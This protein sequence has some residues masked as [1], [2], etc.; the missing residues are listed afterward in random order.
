MLDYAAN[1]ATE[2]KGAVLREWHAERC[3][4]AGIDAEEDLAAIE[5]SL[6][7][8]EAFWARVGENLLLAVEVRQFIAGGDQILQA[9]LPGQTVRAREVKE[10][11][12]SRRPS[13]LS[14]LIAAG[15]LTDGQDL[16]FSPGFIAV[17]A[18][19]PGRRLAS[20]RQPGHRR[21]RGSLHLSAA[22]P[23]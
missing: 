20:A 12:G 10:R 3:R 9:R 23:G 18:P 17:G 7:D 14:V 11:S 22:W 15:D 4:L 19:P 13:V 1:A 16:W 2:W 21:Q 5:P 8:E 6:T